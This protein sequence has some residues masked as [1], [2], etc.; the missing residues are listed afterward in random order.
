[1]SAP[2]AHCVD[3]WANAK[4]RISERKTSSL[5]DFFS[6]RAKVS[7][8]FI[9]K[10]VQSERKTSSLLDFF[11]KRAKVSSRFI[12]KIVQCEWKTKIFLIFSYERGQSSLEANGRIYIDICAQNAKYL[13]EPRLLIGSPAMQKAAESLPL[14][15][16][17]IAFPTRTA[18]EKVPEIKQGKRIIKTS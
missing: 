6:K 15:A 18:K 5:L 4:I 8:R 9:S 13:E 1:M 14:T 3:W 12:S 10:I 11:S 17:E 16:Y 2:P 7:S